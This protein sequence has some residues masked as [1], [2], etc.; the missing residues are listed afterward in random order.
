MP[1]TLIGSPPIVDDRDPL[2]LAADAPL[3][4][5]YLDCLDRQ[6]FDEYSFH[7]PGHKGSTA[8]TGSVV[9]GDHPLAGGLDTVKLR[10]DWL[11][12][13]EARAAAL[14]GADL[15]RFSVSGSTHCNQALAL[16]VGSPGDVVVV[17]RTLHRSLL[18]GLVL[19]G[20]EPVWV[21]PEV[22]HSIGLPTGYAPAK[23]AEALAAHPEAVAVFLS[24]PSYVGTYSDVGAH[25]RVAH[26]AGIPLVVDAAWA[27]HFGFH[28][29]LPP[30]ALAAGA[31]AMITSAHKTLPAYSQAALLLARTER[32]PANRLVRAFEA[33][34]TTSPAGTIMASI[35]A[36][37]ALLERDGEALLMRTIAAVADARARLERMPGVRVL[38]GPG[39]DPAKLTVSIPGTGA[40][41]VEIEADLIAAG[42]PVE[43]ADRDTIVALATIADDPDTLDRFVTALIA[44]IDQRRAAPRPAP[45]AAGWIVHPQQRVSPREAFFAPTETVACADAPGRVS[46]ELIALYPPGVPVLAPGELITPEALGTLASARADGV[47]I[48]YA[49]DPTLGTLEVLAG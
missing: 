35:D 17:A 3:L 46:A 33:L 22:D 4:R 16:S 28:P 23:V 25:A 13:A 44:A 5:A 2:G 24:D 27:A 11:G 34:H 39:V 42:L 14:W 48:A 37:R 40:H 20:L 15:C 19:A 38:A 45:A 43:M 36:A 31:D 30:H 32:L 10:H 29:A 1:P 49:A 12:E 7:T 18:L 41:G 9:A 21:E 8:L 47:R 6:A 26:E